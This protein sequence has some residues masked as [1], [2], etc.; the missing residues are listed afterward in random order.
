[1]T[2]SQK[3]AR[4]EPTQPLRGPADTWICL[5]NWKSRIPCWLKPPGWWCFVTVVVANKYNPYSTDGETEAQ[6]DAKSLS[7]MD[8]IQDLKEPVAFPSA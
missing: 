2:R 8:G 1:M 4:K 5:Q 3:E 6:R 7:N